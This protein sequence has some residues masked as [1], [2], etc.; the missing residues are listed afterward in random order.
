MEK[1]GLEKALHCDRRWNFSRRTLPRIKITGEGAAELKKALLKRET[2]HNAKK[3]PTQLFRL[4]P[5]AFTPEPVRRRVTGMKQ[6][7]I[8]VSVGGVGGRA[9]SILR[10]RTDQL[11][12]HWNGNLQNI[13]LWIYL[14]S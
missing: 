8:D 3:Q 1:K 10:T 14:T 9:A 7:S 4:P 6:D 5:T 12:T 2:I 13:G 11:L